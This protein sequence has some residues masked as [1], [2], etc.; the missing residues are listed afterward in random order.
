MRS[1][2][3]DFRTMI[4]GNYRG[5]QKCLE[6][7]CDPNFF[8]IGS[9]EVKAVNICTLRTAIVLLCLFDVIVL[10]VNKTSFYFLKETDNGI[11]QPKKKNIHL[12]FF[13]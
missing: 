9:W 4:V 2:N 6:W 8:N 12:I 11:I 3:L 10:L 7:R 1:S 5:L 13:T